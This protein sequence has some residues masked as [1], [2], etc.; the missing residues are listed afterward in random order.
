MS[1][2]CPEVRP[3]IKTLRIFFSFHACSCKRKAHEQCV[4]NFYVHNGSLF[5]NIVV[6]PKAYRKILDKKWH[7]AVFLSH[8]Y[9]SLPKKNDFVSLALVP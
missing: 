5:L 2:N 1:K 9:R 8:S 7:N 3:A 6:V 4:D